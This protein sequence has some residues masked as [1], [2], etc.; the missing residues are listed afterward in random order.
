MNTLF[1]DI[2][3]NAITDWS[4]LSDLTDLHCMVIVDEDGRDYRY[5]ADSIRQGLDHLSRADAIVGHNS[6][7]FDYPALHRLYGFKHPRVLDTLIMARCIFP[8]VYAYDNVRGADKSI[9]GSHSLKAWGQRIGCLKSDHGASEDWS[10]WSIEM[11]DYCVQDVIVTQSVYD[12]FLTHKPS[13]TMLDLEHAFARQ[14]RTQEWIGFPFDDRKAEELEKTLCIRRREIGDKLSVMFEPSVLTMKSHLWVTPDG[15]EWDTKKSAVDVGYKDSDITKG[16]NKTKTIPFNPCSRDQISDR[17][18]ARGWKPLAF[19]GKRPQINEKVLRDIGTPEAMLLL[20]YLLVSKRLGQL[21]E[22][23]YA[24]RKLQKN[25]RLHGSVITNGAISGRCTHRNP[26]LAQVPATRAA[27][28][29]ECRSL[30]TAPEGK[31]LVGADASGLELRCLAHYMTPFD[32]GAYT[33]ELLEGDIHTAN[34]NAAGLP[35]RDDAKTFIYAFLYGAGDAKIGSIVGGS[36]KEGKRLKESFLAKTPALGKLTKAVA[37]CVETKGTLTGLDGRILPCRSAHSALN[38]LL[39]SAGAVV[40]KKA[41][42]IF[43]EDASM[44]QYQLHANVH[45]EAQFSC[46]ED[47]ADDLGKL[48]VNALAKAGEELN[49]LCPLDGEYNIGKNWEE[50]H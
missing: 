31:V 41:L 36:S 38:L 32:D 22:G 50:T 25:G 15:K 23:K 30:F 39:Q 7:G 42:V 3:T 28:G 10:K 26:N 43:C 1:F 34:Q 35:T 27:Y 9:R 40:M 19:E 12:Y 29:K 14:M 16:G 8:D 11:E 21:S 24:W 13:K 46:D 37:E 49:F 2:E 5:R 6:I 47:V 17:L 44:Y 4:R 18:M 48:F 33:K 20:E 45:D